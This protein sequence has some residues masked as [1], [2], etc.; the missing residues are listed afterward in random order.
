MDI[1]QKQQVTLVGILY[2]VYALLQFCIVR[3]VDIHPNASITSIK[4]NVGKNI[5]TLGLPLLQLTIEN[6]SKTPQDRQPKTFNSQSYG[7]QMFLVANQ[8]AT[9]SFQSQFVW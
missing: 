1:F 9:K 3:H 6:R 2:H 7:N 5:F 8:L 4:T